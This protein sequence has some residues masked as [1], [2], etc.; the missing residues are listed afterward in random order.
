MAD[1]TKEIKAVNIEDELKQSYLDYAM[2]V[3]VGRALPDARDGLKPV[4]RRVLYAMRELGNDWNKPYKKSARVVGDVIGKYH[5]HGDAAVYD[6]IV[7]MAQDFSLRYLL[8]DGQGNFGSVDGDAPAAMRYTEVRM[9]RMA[10]DLLLDIERDTVDFSP[11]YDGTENIPDVLPTRVP[12]LL[13][14]GSSGIAVGMAT[15]IPPHNIRE[16]IAACLALLEDPDL[17]IKEL[18]THLPGPDFPTGGIIN[19]RMGIVQA[20]HTGRGRIRVRGRAEIL[21]DE[22]SGKETIIITELPFQVNKARLVE[23]IAQLV[24][25]KKLEGI[26]ALRDESDRDGIRVVVELEKGRPGDIVLNNLYK[27]TPLQSV[28]GINMVALEGGRPR[29]LNLKEI[30]NAFLGHRREVITRRSLFLLRRARERAH[31]LEGLAAASSCIDE[32]VTLVRAAA[33]P[34]EAREALMARSWHLGEGILSILQQADADMYR[35]ED[36]D[37]GYGLLQEEGAARYKLSLVQAKAILDLRLHRLTGLEQDKIKEEYNLKIKEINDY[38]NILSD[39]ERLQEVLREELQQMVEDYEDERRTEIMEAAEDLDDESLIPDE[40]RFVVLTHSGYAVAQSP[41]FF[42]SQH[43]GGKGVRAVRFKEEDYV[44]KLIVAKSHDTLLC[45]S[46]WGR[47]YWL[48]VYQIPMSG[49]GTRGRPLVNLLNMKEGET[50]TAVLPIREYQENRYVLMATARGRVKKTALSAYAKPRPSGV[51]AVKLEQGDHLVGVEIT[52][53]NADIMLFS[54]DGR[55]IRFH[56]ASVRKVQRAA[57]GVRGMR[58]KQGQQVIGL[59]VPSPNAVIFCAGSGGYGMRVKADDFSVKGRAGQ[60]VIA[61]KLKG[62]GSKMIGALQV[63]QGDEI[64]LVNSAGTLLRAEADDISLYRR[65]TQGI[66]LIRL[67]KGEKLEGLARVEG[68]QESAGP[69]EVDTDTAEEPR[70]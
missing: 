35:P 49:K 12:N 11:N 52:D 69:E 64:M 17:G 34:E 20:Y 70:A 59:I 55:C 57:Q 23:R 10:H 15:N 48:K 50:V 18:I 36:L 19:G 58:L 38:I 27:H 51:I 37:A 67:Q 28:F 5:P 33:S 6:T 46:N 42:R 43:L 3:I 16:V 53:G 68:T 63:T 61:I 9:T 26:R 54:T 62:E 31:I 56:E 7:R 14:N 29:S 40:E 30:L 65:A 41:D 39:P 32:V 1:F 21:Q 22:D 45:F 13:V 47:I 4:H 25:E 2:S 8:V 60:G 66:K 24:K 44:R